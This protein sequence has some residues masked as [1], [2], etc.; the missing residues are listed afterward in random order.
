MTSDNGRP[1]ILRFIILVIII[2]VTLVVVAALRPLIFDRIV[3]AI[4]GGGQPE[5][6]AIEENEDL[7]TGGAVE[8][9][10]SAIEESPAAAEESPETPIETDDSG[11]TIPVQDSEVTDDDFPTASPAIRHVVQ[12]GETLAQIATRY[13]VSVQ[14]IQQANQLQDVNRITAGMTLLIPQP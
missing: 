11:E 2:I 3:P 6:A 1:E 9:D 12:P 4:I 10:E 8:E 5:P 7:G 13:G 14:M